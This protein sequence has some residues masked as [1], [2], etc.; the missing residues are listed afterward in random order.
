M[1][2]DQKRL[3]K[4]VGAGVRHYRYKK[5]LTQIQLMEL[6][7][8]GAPKTVVNT[9]NG[10]TLPTIDTLEKLADALDVRIVDFFL[11]HSTAQEAIPWFRQYLR[12]QGFPEEWADT[13]AHIAFEWTNS[14]PA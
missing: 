12:T 8:F 6:A 2:E 13:G 3:A 5:G 9:E 10:R 14:V 4:Q 7:G 11:Y 1:D